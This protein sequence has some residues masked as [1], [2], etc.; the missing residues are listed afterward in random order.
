MNDIN[1]NIFQFSAQPTTKASAKFSTIEGN[2]PLESEA[3]ATLQKTAEFERKPLGEQIR[4][5]NH[6]IQNVQRDIHFSIDQESDQ[7]VIQVLDANTGELIRQI[8]E[9]HFLDVARRLREEGEL[10]LIN[11]VG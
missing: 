11:L 3:N 7:T 9:E 8:P 5:L 2:T 1:N 4:T 10:S 6:F